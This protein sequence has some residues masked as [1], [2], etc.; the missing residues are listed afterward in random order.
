MWKEHDGHNFEEVDR[1]IEF[2]TILLHTLFGLS[3]TWGFTN[4]TSIFNFQLPSQ[5]SDSFACVCACECES[6]R[7]AFF[8]D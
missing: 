7:D 5:F 6:E 1:P 2:K 8:L 4:C 3:R